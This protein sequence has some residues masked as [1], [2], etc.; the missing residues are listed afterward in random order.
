MPGAARRGGT[1]TAAIRRTT[2]SVWTRTQRCWDPC[3]EMS[4]GGTAA[5]E[6]VPRRGRYLI[7]RTVPRRAELMAAL[8]VL[9][10]LA[11]LVFAQLTIVLAAFFSPITKAT[12]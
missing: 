12:R 7:P 5:G 4:T 11:H 3:A 6:R 1:H 2:G 8:G 10:V 9:I